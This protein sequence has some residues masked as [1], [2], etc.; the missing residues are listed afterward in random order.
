MRGQGQEASGREIRSLD[1]GGEVIE[2]PN[3]HSSPAALVCP[4]RLELDPN[5]PLLRS[6]GKVVELR[7]TRCVLRIYSVPS[8][9]GVSLFTSWSRALNA[10]VANSVCDIRTVV[11]GGM[12]KS[13]N[14]VSSNPTTDNS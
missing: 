3:V 12:T 5:L 6:M 1:H 9:A 11:S 8:G 4:A 14:R 10:S 7:R 2:D 13:A